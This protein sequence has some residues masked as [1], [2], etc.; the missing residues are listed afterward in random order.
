[1]EKAE[2]A[3]ATTV[4][5]IDIGSNSGRV[6]VYRRQAGGHL[7]LVAGSRA[8]LRLVR[9]VDEEHRLSE[10]TLGRAW[11]ALQDFRAIAAGAGAERVVAVATAAARDAEN[12]AAL[13]GRIRDR[14]GIEV[15]ILSGEEEARFGF[16]GAVRGLPVEHGLVFDLGGGS[17]QVSHF[18]RR[19]IMRSVSLPLGSLRVSD[20]FLRSDPPRPGEV[21]RLRE[22]V[23]GALEEADVGPLE[24]GER[25]VGTGGTV[26]NLAKIDRRARGGYPVTRLH[27]YV[28]ARRRVKEIAALLAGRRE[29][30][31]EAVPGL[32]DERGDSIVGGSLVVQTLAEAVEAPEI[33]VSGQ[34]VREGLAASLVGGE[35]PAPAA[36]REASLASL[37]SRFAGWSPEPA[38]RRRAVAA[39]LYAGL[40]PGGDP[41]VGDALDQGAMV[42][43]LGRSIDFFDRH[44]HVAGI[45]LGTDLLGFSHRGIALLSAVVRSAG[46]NDVR[47]RSYAP[48]VSADDGARVRRA[49]V[50]LALADDIEERCPP[51]TAI[52][53]ECQVERAEVTVTVPQLGGW[54][55]RKI[56]PRF[57]RAFGRRLA[58]RSG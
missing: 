33:V 57:E 39:S 43:D 15:R 55:E 28:I 5:V 40:E 7:Q 54:R 21:R 17:L 10:A 14:L 31:R 22:H 18:R 24:G 41:E 50:I 37:V 11:E 56:G 1:M 16:L 34:G 49:G 29:K 20:A 9:D 4:A 26:R 58:V 53:P 23:R 13:I 32:S 3:P 27:G 36:V 44:E 52:T 25:L 6:V 2:P 47:A 8:S 46:G 30:K 38:R 42:L 19:R 12:G 35:L 51:G 48:L 45:V